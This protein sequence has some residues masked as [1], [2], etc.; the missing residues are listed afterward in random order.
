MVRV[1]T[2][3]AAGVFTRKKKYYVEESG[4][5]MD[6]TE[7]LSLRAVTFIYSILW[8]LISNLSI[9]VVTVTFIK[10][11]NHF[12]TFYNVNVRVLVLYSENKQPVNSLQPTSV[13]SILTE[14]IFNLIQ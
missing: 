6:P 14:E 12:A 7:R 1:D 5:P 8:H 4:Y 13:G 10:S 9:P 2:S 3:I 11:A